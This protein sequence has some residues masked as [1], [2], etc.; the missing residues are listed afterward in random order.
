MS[1]LIWIVAAVLLALWTGLTA[2]TVALLDAAAGVLGGGGTLDWAALVTSWS[3]PTWLLPWIDAGWLQSVQMTMVGVLEGLQGA[4]P[5]LGQILVSWGVPLVWTLWGLGAVLLLALAGGLHVLVRASRRATT[6]L[7]TGG[8]PA[9]VA[10][11]A[12]ANP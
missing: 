11:A 3:V 4:W 7:S 1:V 2:L 10:P 5:A 12:R 9:S 8:S 6:A